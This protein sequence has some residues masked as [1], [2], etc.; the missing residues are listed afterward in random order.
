MGLIILLRLLHLQG[1][2]LLLQCLMRVVQTIQSAI[3]IVSRFA[4]E[5]NDVVKLLLLFH[6]PGILIL[7]LFLST[8]VCLLKLTIQ[9]VNL[10]VEPFAASTQCV[11]PFF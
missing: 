11:D 5:D 6:Q 3:Y 1:F 8:S 9:T 4:V 2:S 7:L 10:V